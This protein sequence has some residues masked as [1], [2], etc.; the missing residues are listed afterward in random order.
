MPDP[1]V[2]FRGC[3]VLQLLSV[4]GGFVVGLLHCRT[5]SHVAGGGVQRFDDRS[6]KLE[7]LEIDVHINMEPAIP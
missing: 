1:S 7:P 4:L 5:H 2:R 3:Q 6:A